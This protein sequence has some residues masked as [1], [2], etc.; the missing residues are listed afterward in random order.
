[1][2]LATATGGGVA[3]VTNEEVCHVALPAQE[4][5]EA[6]NGQIMKWRQRGEAY[7]ACCEAPNEGSR[8]Q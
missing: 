3:G 6:Q 8:A 1:M 4:T 7:V 2:K 5:Y